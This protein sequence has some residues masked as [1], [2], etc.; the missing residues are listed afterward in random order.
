MCGI[1]LGSAP[2][3]QGVRKVV[4][5]V[6]S[7]LVGST[8]L[9]EVLDPETLRQVLAR[10]FDAMSEVLMRHEGASRK[11]LGD[12][13]MAVFGIPTVHEDDALRAV[14]AADEMRAALRELNEQ[15]DLRWGLRLQARTGVNTGEAIVGDPS[16]GEDFV[17]GEAVSVVARLE[18][19]APPREILIGEQTLELVRGAVLVQAVPPLEVPGKSQPVQAFRLL[20]VAAKDRGID[21]GLSSPLVGRERELQVLREAFDRT[22]SA[23][24]CELVTVVG[25][26]GVGKTRLTSDFVRSLGSAA[27]AVTG[28]C[29]SYG[30]GLTFWPLRE[31]VAELAGTEDGDSPDEVLARVTRLLPADEDRA[32][33][34]ERIAGALAVVDSAAY[35]EDTFWAVRN[36]LQA[37]ASERPLV[38]VLED[39]QWAEPTFLEL[40]EYLPVA[41]RYFPVLIIAVTRAELFDTRPNFAQGLPGARRIDLEALSE[42][43]SRA[44]V[45]QLVAERGVATGLFDRVAASAEGNPLFI[46]QLVRMLIDERHLEKDAS[47]LPMPATIH[48]VLAA[49]LDRLDSAELAIVKAAAVIGR[50]FSDEAALLLA[51][52]RDHSELESHLGA[53][54]RKQI[55]EPDGGR[56]AGRRTFSFKHILLRDVAYQAILKARRADLHE[57]YA[58]WLEREAGERASEYQEILGHHLERS[59]RNLSELASMDERRRELAVR[60]ARHL[61]ASGTRA[62]ARGD[63]RPAVSL[64]ERAVSLL[65]DDDPARRDLT[66]KLGIGLAESGDLSRADALLA[67][68]IR[69][70]RRGRA[71]V[72]YHDGAGRQQVV[73]LEDERSPITIG[74]RPDNDIALSWDSEVSRRHAHLLHTAEGWA[75]VDDESRNGSYL[76]GERITRRG[77]LRDGDVFRFGDTVVLFRAPV[78]DEHRERS[79]F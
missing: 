5:I 31:I 42:A 36:L 2:A 43:D 7:D 29:L 49:R 38:V 40:I 3:A 16:Q 13:V 1:A 10:Y 39:V 55:I 15:L 56:F 25:P 23:G 12:A 66:L 63:I 52:R 4:T 22:V 76:N 53:L 54:V 69:A 8:K 57:R 65:P 79:V 75:L 50:S 34:A 60:A 70:E 33:V 74:R 37:V 26:A 62:L 17:S 71:F 20:D 35:P 32:T 27:T 51:G 64:L 30:Q 21:R 72:A 28:R 47:A 19:S 14:R 59:F 18:Q 73:T 46:E 6:L 41:I 24:T 11:F 67:D 78:Q 68:R 58:D 9:G 44:L 45:E 48:A 61:G 77:P